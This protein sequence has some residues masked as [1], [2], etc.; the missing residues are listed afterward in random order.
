MG[1]PESGVT[2]PRCAARALGD[3]IPGFISGCGS[4]GRAL[5]L[6]CRCREFKSHHSD[7]ALGDNFLTPGLRVGYKEVD[8]MLYYEFDTELFKTHTANSSYEGLGS[9]PK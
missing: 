9:N 4:D 8:N 2:K 1:H 6:G 3:L 7:Q 5:H